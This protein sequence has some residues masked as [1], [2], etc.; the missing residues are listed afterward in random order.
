MFFIVAKRRIFQKFLLHKVG[1][2]DTHDLGVTIIWFIA[3]FL[4]V[5]K[6]FYLQVLSSNSFSLK[7]FGLKYNSYSQKENGRKQ[8]LSEGVSGTGTSTSDPFHYPTQLC[9][10]LIKKI[11]FFIEFRHVFIS[12]GVTILTGTTTEN[13]GKLLFH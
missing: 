4:E 2:I 13:R 12:K 6:H 5:L 1:F 10:K 9:S 3:F 8:T 11:L 7:K